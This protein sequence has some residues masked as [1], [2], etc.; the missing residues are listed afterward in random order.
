MKK[1]SIPYKPVL[2]IFLLSFNTLF[3]CVSSHKSLDMDRSNP[4]SELTKDSNPTASTPEEAVKDDLDNQSYHLAERF[5][6]NHNQS[7]D[8]DQQ[9][10]LNREERTYL[11][12]QHLDNA[13]VIHMPGTSAQANTNNRVDKSSKTKKSFLVG[14]LAGAAV[15]G[16]LCLCHGIIHSPTNPAQP[17]CLQSISKPDSS[18][19]IHSIPLLIGNNFYNEVNQTDDFNLDNIKNID[20]RFTE[21]LQFTTAEYDTPGSSTS[22]DSSTSTQNI[23]KISIEDISSILKTNHNNHDLSISLV[24]KL[25]NNGFSLAE[26][27]DEDKNILDIAVYLGYPQLVKGLVDKKNDLYGKNKKAM[28]RAK[29]HAQKILRQQAGKNFTDI[30]NILDDALACLHKQ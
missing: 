14:F 5:L 1:I 22:I 21:A 20:Q 2:L 16:A 28:K 3:A 10:N 9:H 8:P 12:Q 30:V 27:N 24:K 13:T 26:R 7:T 29:E 18:R 6:C 17:L 11:D 23:S 15:T 4:T 19:A 25:K